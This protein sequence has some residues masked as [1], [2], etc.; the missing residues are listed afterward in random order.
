[1]F[2]LIIDY[3]Y[4]KSSTMY[5]KWR[6]FLAFLYIMIS[7]FIYLYVQ[8]LQVRLTKLLKKARLKSIGLLNK[9]HDFE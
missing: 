6:L 9:I 5:Y 3:N 2:L 4:I 7:L 8:Y 1:M